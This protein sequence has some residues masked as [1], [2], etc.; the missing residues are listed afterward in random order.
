MGSAV[1]FWVIAGAFLDSEGPST[2]KSSD[3]ISTSIGRGFPRSHHW[4]TT[5]A[6]KD[7]FIVTCGLVPR[8]HELWEE[9]RVCGYRGLVFAAHRMGP[10]SATPPASNK[11]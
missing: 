5:E 10:I 8:V 4:S 3:T 11:G 9:K 7:F 2:F 1:G 6:S